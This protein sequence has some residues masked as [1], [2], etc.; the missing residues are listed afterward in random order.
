[1][2]A[3]ESNLLKFLQ[4][5]KQF[6][7]PIYQ[8]T[9]SWEKPQCQQLWRDILRVGKDA[10]AAGHFIGSVVYIAKGIYVTSSVPQLLVID[11]QQRLTTLSLLLAAVAQAIACRG[12]D[13]GITA[14]KIENYY[15]FNTEEEGDLQYK[16]LL[17]R[18]DKLTLTRLVEGKDLPDSGISPRVVDTHRYFTDQIARLTDADLRALWAGIEKL[19]IVDIS[20]DREYDNP[21]L[22]FESLNATALKLTESDLIRN[23]VLMDL[24]PEDQAVLYEE[25]WSPIEAG[26]AN[27]NW[28]DW[29]V[30]DYLTV[31]TGAIP[32][33]RDIYATFKGHVQGGGVEGKAIPASDVVAEMHRYARYFVRLTQEDKEP[34]PDLRAA[35]ADLRT[36]EVNVARPY[37]LRLYED[38]DKGLMDKKTMLAALRVVESYVFRRSVCG[39][40]TNTLNKTFAGLDREVAKNDYLNS[41][42]AAL[43][44][45]DS[46]RRFPDDEEFKREITVKDVYNF[47]T[48]NYMLANLENEGRKEPVA[49]AAYTIE[50]ILPQTPNLRPEWRAAL[51]DDWKEIQARLLHTLGN[52]TLTGYNSEYSD[53]PFQEKRDMKGGFK[54]SPLRLNQ[55]LGQLDTW[56]ADEIGAR[57]Q[58]L[59]ER[60]VLV[61][62]HPKLTEQALAACKPPSLADDADGIALAYFAQV[63]QGGTLTLFQE[64]KKRIMNLDASIRMFPRKQF[65]GFETDAAETFASIIPYQGGMRLLLNARLDELDDPYGFCQDTSGRD[66]WGIGDSETQEFKKLEQLDMLIPLVRQAFERQ[67]EGGVGRDNA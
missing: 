4:Q 7:I 36:L 31:K 10:V 17:T 53:R 2:K 13:E 40:A 59:A 15:L 49:V 46:Y 21:Q 25:H 22:I 26:F 20:L 51:G 41:L 29:F 58:K 16:L 28:F 42:Y 39:I 64:I 27:S 56:D 57:A 19:I 47:R 23:Y 62:T 18:T 43:L 52:L 60:A 1:M 61:W 65:I 48:R 5:P 11:G 44:L 50:H 8:R 32:N 6:I 67:A 30:R 12:T 34:D 3:V 33:V 63:L 55:G 66:H 9:Y 38:Y 54:E 45:K 14:K 37:L 35:L 24:S